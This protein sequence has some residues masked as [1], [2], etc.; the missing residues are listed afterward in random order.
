MFQ[1][2]QEY[3][4]E[5]NSKIFLKYD[6][7]R[8]KEKHTAVLYD[9]KDTNLSTSKETDYLTVDF[10]ELLKNRDILVSQEDYEFF[11]ITFMI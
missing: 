10:F 8:I 2:F 9:L 1:K 11:Y 3:L 7:E 4:K 5:T 6:G